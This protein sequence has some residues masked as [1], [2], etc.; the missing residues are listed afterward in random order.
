VSLLTDNP[1]GGF[2]SYKTCA[3]FY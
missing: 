1:S 2:W 3:T